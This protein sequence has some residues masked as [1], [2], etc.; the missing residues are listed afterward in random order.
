[1]VK[2]NCKNCQHWH[3]IKERRN[4]LWQMSMEESDIYIPLAKEYLTIGINLDR[5]YDVDGSGFCM[6]EKT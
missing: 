5:P 4:L 3:S 6:V 1:M 2:K